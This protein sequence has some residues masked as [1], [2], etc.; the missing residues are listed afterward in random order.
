MRLGARPPPPRWRAR[1][2]HQ[3]GPSHTARWGRAGAGVAEG[4]RGPSLQQ[5]P[6]LALSHPQQTSCATLS[7]PQ[8]AHPQPRP[9]PAPGFSQGTPL[10]PGA[11]H[12]A[13]PGKAQQGQQEPE[14]PGRPPPPAHPSRN[15]S[16]RLCTAQRCSPAPP[17]SK[18]RGPV[19]STKPGWSRRKRNALLVTG[20]KV[21]SRHHHQGPVEVTA[22]LRR[23]RPRAEPA[24][25][26]AFPPR[27]SQL[28]KLPSDPWTLVLR[29]GWVGWVGWVGSPPFT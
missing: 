5:H 14:L 4:P 2:R 13:A 23:P 26:S 28:P 27:C 7:P 10:I 8:P 15:L 21:T 17:P 1:Q 25:G 6:V 16:H 19:L 24:R 22:A 18:L 29:R 12:R 3:D 11:P 20:V 9:L